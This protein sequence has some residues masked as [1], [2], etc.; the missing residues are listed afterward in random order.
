MTLILFSTTD[1]EGHR[2]LEFAQ[3]LI[4]IERNVR[5]GADV[6]LYVLLQ[7]C[8]SAKLAKLR[9][10]VP[11]YCR[12]TAVA[13]RC[14]LSTAR[15]RLIAAALVSIRPLARC[16]ATS[17]LPAARALVERAA[18]IAAVRRRVAVCIGDRILENVI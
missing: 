14:S 12:L 15:N 16:T 3:L 8:A 5:N 17:F 1:L 7:N 10:W 13:G 4:S 6:R 11:P 9:K 18:R 2:G